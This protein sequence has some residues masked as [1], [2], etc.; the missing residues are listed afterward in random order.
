M[1]SKFKF[2][3]NQCMQV[4]YWTIIRN[5][6]NQSELLGT[7][8]ALGSLDDTRKFSYHFPR[9]SHDLQYH[10]ISDNL[11]ILIETYLVWSSSLIFL[12]S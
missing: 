2:V 10:I 5:S 3:L 11:I 12:F 6:L 1:N 4:T 8:F 7:R 9:V